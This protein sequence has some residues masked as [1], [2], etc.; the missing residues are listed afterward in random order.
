MLDDENLW[1]AIYDLYCLLMGRVNDEDA[2]QAFL[3]HHS[4]VFSVLGLDDAKSFEKR[5]TY[6]LPFDDDRNFRP[7]PDFVGVDRAA[8]RIVIVELKTPFVD[9]ITTSRSDGNRAKFKASAESY[10]SQAT[11][12]AESIRQ[13]ADARDVI[14]H[15]L[16]IERVS[17]YRVVLIY[18]I[19]SNNDARLVSELAAQRKIPTE[20]M[21]YDSLL[22][23]MVDKYAFNRRDKLSRPGWCF[24]FHL[25][26]DSEQA[27][28]RSFL[29]EYGAHTEDRVS[30]FLEDS[31]L[32]FEC[33]DAERC[34]HRL[35]S[36]INGPGPH[37]IRF[38]FSNDENGIYM[39]L[40]VNNSEQDLRVGRSRLRL[41]PDTTVFTLGADSNGENGARFVMLEHYAVSRTM[42][43]VEKLESFYYFKQKTKGPLRGAEFKTESFM[44]RL[45]SGH[46]VQGQ[47][48]LKPVLREWVPT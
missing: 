40:N 16:N 48:E 3:E 2:Y 4:I 22:E 46:L 44:V 10:I 14:K 24:V 41:T 37:Y 35:Q 45:P 32:V 11:E 12:Y 29:G 19:S 25:V 47:E 13:R 30:V 7:E 21:F 42:D 34:A 43:I 27:H 1:Q 9:E 28:R 20:I 15:A 26:L 39:S 18:G 6:S 31:A 23:N 38:E 17:D 8:G 5:S 33:L 36:P